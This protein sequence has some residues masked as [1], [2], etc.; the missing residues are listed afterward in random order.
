MFN[1]VIK[2]YGILIYFNYKKCNLRRKVAFCDGTTKLL[3]YSAKKIYEINIT[4]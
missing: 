1:F 4:V 3:S 2:N